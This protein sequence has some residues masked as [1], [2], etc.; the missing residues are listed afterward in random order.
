MDMMTSGGS[1]A[2]TVMAASVALVSEQ[3]DG[4]DDHGQALN[5]E[6]GQPVLQQLL[7]VLDVA[8][9]AAHDDAG[10]LLGEEVEREPLQVPEDLD[11]QVVHDPRG[12][13]ARHPGLAPLGAAPTR[14]IETR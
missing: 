6:L 8:R 3:E 14:T 9:H 11:A 1:T 2:K 7:Q 13:A 5:G 4:D 12:Q 10:L